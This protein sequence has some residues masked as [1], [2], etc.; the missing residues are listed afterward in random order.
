MLLTRLGIERLWGGG[1]EGAWPFMQHWVIPA[2]M[3]LAPGSYGYGLDRVPEAGGAVLAANHLS[4]IDPPLVGSFSRRAIWYMMKSELYD[5]PLIGEALSWTGA[6]PI[7]R[8]ERDRE[9]IRRARLLVDDGHVVGV[10]AEGTR[11]RLGYPG[12]V[13][14]GAAMIAMQQGVPL[15][16][17]GLESFGWSRWNPRPCCVV[18]GE[19]LPLDDLPRNGRGYKEGSERLRQELLRLWRQAAEA[20]A[21][22]F[23]ER[24]PD[25][26]RRSDPLRPGTIVRTDGEIRNVSALD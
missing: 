3:A 20:V 2:T 4:A 18:F 17:C 21:G 9:G 7:R 5:M 8:R 15:V 6:F 10:F 14:P 16:P 23:P 11:Q 13:Q 24:L 12:Q 25:G 22:A 19:P 1:P 26:T